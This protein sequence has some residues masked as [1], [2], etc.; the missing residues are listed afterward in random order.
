[1]L[2]VKNDFLE[3]YERHK[4]KSS[5]ISIPA[6]AKL[7]GLQQQFTYQL[8]E[9]GLIGSSIKPGC[10]SRWILKQNISDFRDQYVLLSKLA[11]RVQVSSRTLLSYLASRQIYPVDQDWLDPLRQ[12]VYERNRLVNVQLL[13]G[14]I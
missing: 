12:K 2:F 13:A 1:M 10:S 7:L 4:V 6:T 14:Y 5:L 11:K 3:W 9:A 8:V